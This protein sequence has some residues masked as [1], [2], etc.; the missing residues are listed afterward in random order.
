MI[1]ITI[2][3]V[4]HGV[5]YLSRTIGV[6]TIANDGTGTKDVGNYVYKLFTEEESPKLWKTGEIKGFERLRYTVW[7]LLFLILQDISK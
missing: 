6:A 4:P 1:R 2:E 5:E 7:K 3:L